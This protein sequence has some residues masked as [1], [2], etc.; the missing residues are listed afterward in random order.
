MVRAA[1]LFYSGLWVPWRETGAAAMPPQH[2]VCEVCILKMILDFAHTRSRLTRHPNRWGDRVAKTPFQHP[3][4]ATVRARHATFRASSWSMGAAITCA[5]K[6]FL[7]SS[8]PP[9]SHITHTPQLHINFSHGLVVW[10]M[11]LPYAERQRERLC[12][13][14]RCRM[15]EASLSRS[16]GSTHPGQAAI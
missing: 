14:P 16:R 11:V 2:G 1:A 6:L 8:Q 15:F 10:S 7:A 12:W 5:L 9:R 13:R 4:G 3:Y